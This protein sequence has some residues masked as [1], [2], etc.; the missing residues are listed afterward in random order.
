MLNHVKDDT[1]E[2]INFVYWLQGFFELR[3]PGPISREQAD[4]IEEHLSLVLDKKTTNTMV[5]PRPPLTWNGKYG[6]GPDMIPV[7]C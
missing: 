7:S 2:S 1:I 3:K 6:L 5:G 4:I